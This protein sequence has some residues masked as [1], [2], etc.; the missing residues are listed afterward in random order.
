[1]AWHTIRLSNPVPF[2]HASQALQALLTRAT[3]TDM[4]SITTSRTRKLARIYKACLGYRIQN[5]SE[6]S[7]LASYHPS[8]VRFIGC[9]GHSGPYAGCPP[10]RPPNGAAIIRPRRQLA[11]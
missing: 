2:I 6:R 4:K 7:A 3:Y 5:V 1:M 10:N 11:P 9:V 8:V